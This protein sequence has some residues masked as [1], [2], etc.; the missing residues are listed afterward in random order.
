MADIVVW[1]SHPLALGATPQQVWIDGISQITAPQVIPKP[2]ELQ[3]TPETPNFDKEVED[4]LSHDGLP[5][6]LPN[7][8]SHGTVVFTNVSEVYMRKNA[9]IHELLTAQIEPGVVVVHGGRIVCSGTASTCQ[10]TFGEHKDTIDL[11][12]GS[13]TPGLVTF[14]S[15]LGLQEI[16]GEVSTSD[17]LIL[18]PLLLDIPELAGGGRAVIRAADGLQYITRDA[19]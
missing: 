11:H 4:T 17:G 10:S 12:G 15:P 16:S 8:T 2:D 18:D 6:L 3:Y 13:I 1:D 14:G 19:L 9:E 5:P 7:K